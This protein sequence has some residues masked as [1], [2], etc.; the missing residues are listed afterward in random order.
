VGRK[1]DDKK[2]RSALRKI[3]RAKRAAE[4]ASSDDAKLSDWEGEFIDSVEERLE[5]FGS[6]FT[7]PDKG[8]LDNAL[9]ARQSRKLKEIENK[10]KGKPR[11]PM[12]RGSGFGAGKSGN[13]TKSGHKN[14]KNKWVSRDRDINADMHD[15]EAS[16][17]IEPVPTPQAPAKPTRPVEIIANPKAVAP[18]RPSKSRGFSPRIIEG[19]KRSR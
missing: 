17:P 15:E 13:T 14:K 12:S 18:S 7:D 16:L 19:G 9:S 5:K 10:A 3:A 1:V 4:N 11:K 2:T 6:A 8:Q